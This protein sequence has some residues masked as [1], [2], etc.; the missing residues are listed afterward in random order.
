MIVALDMIGFLAVCVLL[1]G[2]LIVAG[3]L[4][5][6]AYTGG[7]SN[8]FLWGLRVFFVAYALSFMMV[9]LA[10]LLYI[11]GILDI[12]S[13]SLARKIVARLIQA[14]GMAGLLWSLWAT[15]RSVRG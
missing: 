15:Q 13:Y 10:D 1:L 7:A 9:L 4:C 5:R 3:L 11:Q 2:G 6:T 12:L 8:G 14:G